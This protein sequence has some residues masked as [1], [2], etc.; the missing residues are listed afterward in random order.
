MSLL[1]LFYSYFQHKSSN[2]PHGLPVYF[3][4]PPPHYEMSLDR[5][6]KSTFTQSEASEPYDDDS[7]RGSFGMESD[8]MSN[9]S[10]ELSNILFELQAF[11]TNRPNDTHENK[12]QA[13]SHTLPARRDA[14]MATDLSH[15]PMSTFRPSDRGYAR[16]EITYD[17]SK[18]PSYTDHQRV[19]LLRGKSRQEADPAD[20]LHSPSGDMYSSL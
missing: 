10:S 6:K 12:P 1:F 2:A 7:R 11:D 17:E 13:S 5:K 20:G 14:P 9:I 3:P 18:P 4:A 8:R 19:R 15:S 16:T